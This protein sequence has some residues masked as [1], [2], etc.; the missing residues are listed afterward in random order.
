[1]PGRQQDPPAHLP[2]QP[3]LL[4]DDEIEHIGPLDFDDDEDDEERG[5]VEEFDA[6]QVR[7]HVLTLFAQGEDELS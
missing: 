3:P 2:C 4:D 1:M 5:E 6:E 7:R